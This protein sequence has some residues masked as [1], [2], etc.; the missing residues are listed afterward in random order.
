MWDRTFISPDDEKVKQEWELCKNYIIN[1]HRIVVD[2]RGEDLK[3]TKK[4]RLN[5]DL[6]KA[7]VNVTKRINSA[8]E[9]IEK[10]LPT[11]AEHLKRN[12]LTG[13]ICIYKTNLDNPINWDISW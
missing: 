3:F 7:R 8:I 10:D 1:A 4:S 12:I 5:E 9:D 6:E 13:K 11:L 2:D